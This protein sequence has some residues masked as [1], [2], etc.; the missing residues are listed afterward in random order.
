VCRHSKKVRNP[1]SIVSQW[2]A[3]YIAAL[4]VFP[5]AW[6]DD[7]CRSDE[8]TCANGKCIQKR[9]V[10]DRDDDC[11]DGSD[12][13]N[14]PDNLCTPHSEF[15]CSENFCIT[16]RWRCD[17]DLDCP[18]GSDEEVGS[19]SCTSLIENDQ[20]RAVHQMKLTVVF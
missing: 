2:R 5:C 14:C 11:G 3:V 16:S 15:N 4:Y 8:F 1:W 18:D 17:G 10:C 9:W 19:M 12:E 20:W 13:R 6:P 7:T